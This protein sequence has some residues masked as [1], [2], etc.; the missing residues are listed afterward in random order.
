M[1]AVSQEAASAVL[2]SL[3][4]H[5]IGPVRGLRLVKQEEDQFD[6]EVDY[7][8]ERDLVIQS[9]DSTILIVED[10]LSD[11]VSDTILDVDYSMAEPRLVLRPQN[12][13]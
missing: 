8:T 10:R 2:E 6:L 1:I 7:P 9:E 12:S 3:K 13:K 4:A 11:M 5:G